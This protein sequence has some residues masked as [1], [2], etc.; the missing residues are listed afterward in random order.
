[1]RT[2]LARTDLD[3]EDR[4]HLDFALAK[5]L[6]DAGDYEQSFAHYDSANTLRKKKQNYNAEELPRA[7]G[8]HEGAVHAGIFRRAGRVGQSSA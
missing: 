8:A 7:V 4:Y 1:M 5:A 6:E 2:Q 3:D